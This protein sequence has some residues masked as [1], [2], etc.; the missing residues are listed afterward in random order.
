MERLADA[1]RGHGASPFRELC[2][3]SGD[4]RMLAHV[5]HSVNATNTTNGKIMVNAQP[6]VVAESPS[7]SWRVF[8]V[9]RRFTLRAEAVEHHVRMY[10]C[11]CF[12]QMTDM[13]RISINLSLVEDEPTAMFPEPVFCLP[14]CRGRQ[15][16]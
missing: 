3:A 6:T 1:L 14:G 2:S 12:L 11:I 15:A 10:V 16:R 8:N 7:Q 13:R 5:P 9:F 4:Q